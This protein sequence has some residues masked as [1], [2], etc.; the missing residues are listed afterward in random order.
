MALTY[1]AAVATLYQAPQSAFVAERKRLAAEL[2]AGGDKAGAAGLAKLGRPTLS[3]WAVNQLWW[4]ARAPFEA[5]LA[6]GA[7][8]REG[9]LGAMSAHRQA[10]AKLRGRAAELLEE[11]GHAANEATL[12]RV[13]TTLAALAASGGFDPEPAGALSA[14]RDPPGFESAAFAS[15]LPARVPEQKAA[16]P[17]KPEVES[18]P[19]RAKAP[20]RATAAAKHE[21]AEAK[22]REKA[23]AERARI[24]AEAERRRAQEQRAK[25]KAQ[26]QRLEA[27]L[28]SAQRE[29]TARTDEVESAR[30]ELAAA[31]QRV[32]K[33]QA[34]V[35]RLE[36][37]LGE[38]SADV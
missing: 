35:E 36:A 5:L 3:A 33:Q 22:R 28:R 10:T 13:T 9:D 37:R 31:E 7:R 19:A 2:K 15:A 1:E 17:S 38:L 30:Q 14:D 12:R 27:E 16:A 24:E 25:Q 4:K 18:K 11:G 23:E 21:L 26:R 6:T 8:L 34:V 32:A 29:L 20:E